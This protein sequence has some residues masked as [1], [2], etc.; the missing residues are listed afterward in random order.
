MAFARHNDVWGL[1]RYSNP[2]IRKELE[3]AG[4]TCVTFDLS[5][6]DF[7]EVPDDFD[8][9]FN[10]AVS[11]DP[12]FDVT[13]TAIVEGLGFLMSHCRKAKAFFHCSTCGVYRVSGHRPMKETDPLGDSH[14]A[15]LPSYS[16]CKIAAEGMARFCARKWS[17]PTVIAR[18]NVPYGDNGG[19]PSVHME[20]ILAG[21]PVAVHTNKPCLYNPIHEDDIIETLPKL[22]ETAAVPAN[23]VNWAG[24]EQV[25]LEDWSNYIARL[26]GKT[27]TF[28]YTGDALDSSVADTEKME[29][30]TGKTKVDWKDGMRRMVR[31]RHP[32]IELRD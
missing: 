7:Y 17:L 27:V 15:L 8:F 28:E 11:F 19:W 3:D 26:V 6:P 10:F 21:L 9:V 18:L 12:N 1:A 25:S 16:I 31:A 30:I 2:D 5:K 4:I 24:T 23:T 29:T 20:F 14:S 22:M 32:E 13:I